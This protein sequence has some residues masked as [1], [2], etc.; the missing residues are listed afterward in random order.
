MHGFKVTPM[1]G[2]TPAFIDTKQPSAMAL[3]DACLSQ[4]RAWERRTNAT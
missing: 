2:R 4:T 3:M 1:K